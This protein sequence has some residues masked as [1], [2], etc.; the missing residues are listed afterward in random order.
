MTSVFGI[1]Y[2]NFIDKLYASIGPVSVVL[3]I[4]AVALIGGFGVSRIC[5]LLKIPYVTGYIILGIILGPSLWAVVP[6]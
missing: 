4:M 5:K 2:Q 3:I 6:T 1:N